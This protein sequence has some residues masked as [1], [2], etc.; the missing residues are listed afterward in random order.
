MK[1]LAL[2]IIV[3]LLT[4]SL[5]A[6]YEYLNTSFSGGFSTV[7]NM[8]TV[9]IGATYQVLG[10]ESSQFSFGLGSRTD[11]NL[12]VSDIVDG[13][14]IGTFI[15]PAFEINLSNTASFNLSSGLSFY[16]ED[17]F[18]KDSIDFSSFGLGFDS[19][20]NYYFDKEENIGLSLG[21][22][23]YLSFMGCGENSRGFKSDVA[24]Y[25]GISMRNFGEGL[26]FRDEYLDFFFY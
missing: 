21:I 14:S 1:K 12:V 19:A 2:L 7:R 6:D 16:T 5:Y 20:F 22:A 11:L 4:F 23:G 9:G 13:I 10:R 25:V 24:A 17:T 3:A 18:E 8:P 15:G 26:E